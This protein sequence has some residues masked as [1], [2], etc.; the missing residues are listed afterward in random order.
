MKPKVVGMEAVGAGQRRQQ[1]EEEEEEDSNNHKK[2]L[3][4]G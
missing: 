1:E 2:R 3:T 4:E